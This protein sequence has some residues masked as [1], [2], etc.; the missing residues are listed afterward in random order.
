MAV[1][2]G[3]PGACGTG[4]CGVEWNA[5][6]V[7]GNGCGGWWAEPELETVDPLDHLRKIEHEVPSTEDSIQSST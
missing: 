3:G 1:G 5:A 2:A 7:G 4:V 6:D